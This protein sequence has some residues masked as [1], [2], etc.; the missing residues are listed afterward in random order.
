M[1][2]NHE[3]LLEI[4]KHLPTDFE[5][6]GERN[7]EEGDCSC[8]CK[9]FHKLEGMRGSDWG[10][11]FNPKSPRKGLLT[12]EHQGCPEHEFDESD[13]DYTTE[14]HRVL[15]D[16]AALRSKLKTET[17]DKNMEEIAE[18]TTIAKKLTIYMLEQLPNTIIKNNF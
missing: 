5:P 9:F 6:Y 16:N 10:I 11:C 14:L 15:Q 4:V 18:N 1:E 7:R 17:E 13:S 8:G 3:Q 2:A 12:F